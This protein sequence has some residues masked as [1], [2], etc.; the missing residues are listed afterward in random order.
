[1]VSQVERN[2]LAR[3]RIERDAASISTRNDG[4][5]LD[6]AER[7][8]GA[9]DMTADE[10]RAAGWRGRPSIHMPRWAS[11]ITL[12]VTAVRPERLHD[13]SEE[14]AAAEGIEFDGNWWRAGTHP[15][16]GT[17]QCWPSARRA[18]ER[19]WCEINGEDSWNA[20]AWLWVYAFRRVDTDSRANVPTV[21]GRRRECWRCTVSEPRERDELSPTGVPCPKC[22]D[23]RADV[24]A[25]EALHHCLACHHCWDEFERLREEIATLRASI[26]SIGVRIERERSIV[27][28]VRT[29]A[30]RY[31]ARLLDR[32]E[33]AGGLAQ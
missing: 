17:L 26:A 22:G 32:I 16:K 31:A 6:R 33:K 1:L 24:D 11:R 15:V 13:I 25:P 12:E 20:N 9:D 8:P 4:G 27:F 21:E 23:A 29:D 10:L 28:G 18:F 19:L 5:R 3:R 2:G 7:I 30:A 14:D